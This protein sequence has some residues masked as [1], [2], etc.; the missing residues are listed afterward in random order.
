MN[1]W[2]GRT[3]G[4]V[5]GYQ[6]F[7]FLIKNIGVRTSYFFLHFVV[8]FYFIFLSNARKNLSLTYKQIIKPNPLN[9][10]VLIYSN[11]LNLGKNLIDSVAVLTPHKSKYFYT[12]KGAKYLVE[13]FNNSQPAILISAHIGNWNVAGELIKNKGGVVN[14]VMFD[15]EDR[16]IKK[17][18][19]DNVGVNTY[20]VILIKKDLSH[21]FKIKNA[22]EEVAREGGYTYILDE[23]A[24]TILYGDPTNN[25][26]SLVK[27][28]L[29]L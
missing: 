24:G 1:K 22:I 11:F 12:G 17:L 19:E 21:L 18:M 4:F 20:K 29:G 25:V 15:G 16:K 3:K 6:I 13:L 8:P 9:L 28:R 2:S 23:A 7:I 14:I 10:F 5:L 26:T 27:K